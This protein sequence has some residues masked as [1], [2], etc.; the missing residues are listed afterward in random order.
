MRPSRHS[1][2]GRI[3]LLAIDSGSVAFHDD[4]GI[5]RIRPMSAANPPPASLKAGAMGVGIVATGFIGA[6]SACAVDMRGDR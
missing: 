5:S 6:T 1:F 4:C 2:P 3:S